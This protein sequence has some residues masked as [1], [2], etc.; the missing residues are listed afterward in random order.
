MATHSTLPSESQAGY[1]PAQQQE[2]AV[3]MDNIIPN[4]NPDSGA[5]SKKRLI[6][7][8]V[9]AILII[10]AVAIAASVIEFEQNEDS[11]TN[12][13]C[14]N[15]G[16]GEEINI[17]YLDSPDYICG[18]RYDCDRNN[19]GTYWLT[20]SSP[21]FSPKNGTHCAYLCATEPF[22]SWDIYQAFYIPSSSQCY[23]FSWSQDNEINGY[24]YYNGVRQNASWNTYCF[25]TTD[26]VEQYEVYWLQWIQEGRPFY[27]DITMNNDNIKADIKQIDCNKYEYYQNDEWMNFI[28]NFNQNYTNM[29][30]R[31]NGYNEWIEKGLSEHASIA[32]FSKFKL[33]LMGIGAPLWLIQ[34]ANEATSDEIRHT[35]IAFD[36]ANM[37]KR[38][39]ELCI[40]S[41]D[42]P[43]HTINIDGDWNKI[44][45]DT[46]IGGAFGET[47][48]ALTMEMTYDDD[49]INQYIYSIKMDEIRH[50]ALAWTTI[51]WMIDEGINI[52]VGNKEWW[53]N[54]VRMRRGK[55]IKEQEIIHN[56][57]PLIIDELWKDVTFKEFHETVTKILSNDLIDNAHCKLI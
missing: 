36:I 34:L 47:I 43:S 20:E 16:G 42:F 6:I 12:W 25:N 32:T 17:D 38:N 55:T 14:C 1:V 52:D 48:S 31:Y 41:N 24:Y 54:E 33:E 2:V 57:I 50:S 3:N 21:C 4:N 18:A 26:Y 45:L 30:D 53:E 27:I 40:T 49:I 29:N 5:E 37:M 8:A 22:D 51:K 46:A 15:W 9:I 13:S 39:E 28:S 35:Q 11:D 19:D 10:I 56:T 7:I 44:A 23:C